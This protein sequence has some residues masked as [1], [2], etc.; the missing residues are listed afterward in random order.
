MWLPPEK[1]CKHTNQPPFLLSS[2]RSGMKAYQLILGS[3]VSGS[4]WGT[5]NEGRGTLSRQPWK[6]M[7]HGS[8]SHLL[9][10]PGTDT[11]PHRLIALRQWFFKL[12]WALASP[13]GLSKTQMAGPHTRASDSV[14]LERGLGT[15]LCNEFSGHADRACSRDQF[16]NH[17]ADGHHPEPSHSYFPGECSFRSLCDCLGT[18]G[19]PEGVGPFLVSG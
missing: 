8:G 15:C 4:L 11:H 17:C 16:E 19:I 6:L 1:E 5:H 9:F 7:L 12:G 14:S 13:G 2:K 18:S 10:P 3:W